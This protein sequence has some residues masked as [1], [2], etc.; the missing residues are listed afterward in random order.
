MGRFGMWWG[1]GMARGQKQGQKEG[2]EEKRDRAPA[3]YPVPPLPAGAVDYRNDPTALLEQTEDGVERAGTLYAGMAEGRYV[4]G[5]VQAQADPND[6]GRG[7]T[8][9]TQGGGVAAV[10][11][12]WEFVNMYRQE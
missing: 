11:A 4:R 8:V 5:G 1:A 6:R 2:R 12:M 10:R 7:R 3:E 9:E